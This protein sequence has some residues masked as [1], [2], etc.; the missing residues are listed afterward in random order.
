MR[1]LARRLRLAVVCAIV[2][3]SVLSGCA[4]TTGGDARDPLESLNR[5]IYT[6]ND[7]FDTL[8]AKPIAEVYQ[9]VIP[10]LVRTGVSNV[11]ANLY[12]VTVALNNLL[13]GKIVEALSDASRVVI[14]TTVGLLGV[15]DIATEAGLEKHDEDFG[16]T[17]G[18]WGMDDGPYL[19]L[20]FLG[21]STLRDAFGR[22]V[23]WGSD[24]TTYLQPN[25]DRN[26]VQGFRLVT[27]RAELLRASRLLDV[28]ALD[29]YAFV[30]D[31]YLQRRRNL[32]HDGNPPREKDDAT[33]A[34]PARDATSA[35]GVNRRTAEP[36]ES[37]LTL[38]GS[39]P[40]TPTD[41]ETRLRK[42]PGPVAEPTG[43]DDAATPAAEEPA[44]RVWLSSPN[45]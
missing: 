10:P 7:G 40:P 8:L 11:F 6:F 32:I 34:T 19:I 39:T 26:A 5:G 15:F 27:R 36:A 41:E 18:Y 42:V 25:R 12:D 23:D 17:L 37:G 24:P 1:D 45:Q 31:A 21:P 22:V 30:R 9:G 2:G 44:V 14:N 20:P 38:L 16:Q 28:A 29:E 3:L 43:A 4:T 35:R 13:Q 33:E